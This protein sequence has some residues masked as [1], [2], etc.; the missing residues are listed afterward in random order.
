MAYING[1]E[2]LFSS[3]VVGAGFAA[4]IDRS[5]SGKLVIPKEVKKIGRYAFYDCEK[6][7]SIIF[8]GGE[9]EVG[10]LALAECINLK[11]CDFRK[12]TI[13]PPTAAM[14]SPLN[15]SYNAFA[16]VPTS[17]YADWVKLSGWAKA[18]NQIASDSFVHCVNTVTYGEGSTK[19]GS[20]TQNTPKIIY[21][22]GHTT[23]NG[24]L[25]VSA[26]GAISGGIVSYKYRVRETQ[27]EWGDCVT[28]TL[29]P[30]GTLSQAH[31][32][33]VEARNLGIKQYNTSNSRAV[34]EVDCSAYIGKIVDIQIGVEAIYDEY[35]PVFEINRVLAK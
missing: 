16:I 13:V 19:Y 23:L 1:N 3:S 22:T 10:T 35:I 28:A 18:V 21:A 15:G 6:L 26:W 17:L 9:T 8:H 7:E 32:D 25:T 20:T 30:R 27:G 2:I 12:H 31:I 11:L 4:L 14:Y 5:I 34:V 24:I 33:N 29:N